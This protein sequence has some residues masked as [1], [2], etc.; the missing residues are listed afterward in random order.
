MRE[1]P[2]EQLEKFR[3]VHPWLGPSPVGAMYGYFEVAT[4]KGTLRI[5]A[6]DGTTDF[7]EDWQHVSVSLENRTPTWQEMCFVKS[8]FWDESET[9]VQFHPARS[10]YVNAMKH[11]L[12]LWAR[13]GMIYNLPPTELIGPRENTANG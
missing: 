12:H 11:C 1:R 5:Q 10:A 13:R 9:V 2:G 7:E 8:L 4:K 6:S 3:K